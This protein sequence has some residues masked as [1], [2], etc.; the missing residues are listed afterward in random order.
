M[1]DIKLSNVESKVEGKVERKTT[2]VRRPYKKLLKLS[3]DEM[4]AIK[5][6]ANAYHVDAA[7]AIRI[8]I[9]ELARKLQTQNQQ[10][11]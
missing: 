10:A 6:I 3:E 7:N 2:R 11:S 9:A 4:N 5:I 8:A 1:G